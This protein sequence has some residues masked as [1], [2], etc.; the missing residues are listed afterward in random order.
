MGV[1]DEAAELQY[2]TINETLSDIQ[3][4]EKHILKLENKLRKSQHISG[5]APLPPN[6]KSPAPPP[7]P[8]LEKSMHYVMLLYS[9]H[10][11]RVMIYANLKHLNSRRDPSLQKNY[12]METGS[13]M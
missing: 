5:N 11:W 3:K 9:T 8:P 1:F 6:W 13:H 12:I 2:L 7:P 10:V 4:L